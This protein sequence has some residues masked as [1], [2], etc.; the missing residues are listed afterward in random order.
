VPYNDLKEPSPITVQQSR[1]VIALQLSYLL[2]LSLSQL[3]FTFGSLKIET[4]LVFFEILHVHSEIGAPSMAAQGETKK[5]AS[6]RAVVAAGSIV[7]K[8]GVAWADGREEQARDFI[9]LFGNRFDL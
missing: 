9:I 7:G 1:T 6:K 3:K 2:L 5:D 4:S 8:D